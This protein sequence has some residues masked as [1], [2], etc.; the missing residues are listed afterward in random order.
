MLFFVFR[1]GP[2]AIEMTAVLNLRVIGAGR[3]AR[4]GLASAVWLLN[5]KELHIGVCIAKAM[6]ACEGVVKAGQ[7]S[8]YKLSIPMY[9]FGAI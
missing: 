8:R 5:D 7:R 4:K 9:I 6:T 1:L 3:D 2:F